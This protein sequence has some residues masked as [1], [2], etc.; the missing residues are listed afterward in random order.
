MDLAA[1]PDEEQFRDDV[2]SWL[3]QNLPRLP[4]PEPADLAG[5]AAFW[6]QWQR[7][8]FEAGYAGLTWPT[9]YGGQ[10]IGERMRAIFGEECDRAG[11]RT[12]STSSVRTSPGPRSR[13]SA[14]PRRRSV[15]SGRS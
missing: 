5:K 10:G 9:E 12:G 2:R 11:A 4:W 15:T 1:A 3:Q 6:R 13:T 8:L 14:P 7:M